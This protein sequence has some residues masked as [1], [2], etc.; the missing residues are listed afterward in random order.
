MSRQKWKT[1][2]TFTVL[3]L[4]LAGGA[5]VWGYFHRST[6]TQ[7]APQTVTRVE[8]S[9]TLPGTFVTTPTS[10]A[11]FAEGWL[12]LPKLTPAAKRHKRVQQMRAVVCPEP[13]LEARVC[14]AKPL[15][16]TRKV[17]A[18]RPKNR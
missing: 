17:L 8:P 2:V 14:Y 16:T 18:L 15:T 11:A 5:V 7:D 3:W 9:P 10:A 1:A 6:S 4:T 13:A 12:L